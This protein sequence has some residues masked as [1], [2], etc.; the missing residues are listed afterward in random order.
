M[1][2]FLQSFLKILSPNQILS[3]WYA[4]S[5]LIFLA[6]L[7]VLHLG[8]IS[9]LIINLSDLDAVTGEINFIN[10]MANIIN[11][12]LISPSVI[13][14]TSIILFAI[15]NTLISTVIIKHISVFSQNLGI[16]IKAKIIRHYLSLTWEDLGQIP[17]S[18][19]MSRILNDG[20][21]VADSLYFAL[22]LMSKLVLAI[23]ISALLFFYN[24][25]ITLFIVF[26][27]SVSYC[28][29][30]YLFSRSIKKNSK[31]VSLAE[32][33]ILQIL[34]NLFGSL[35]EIIFYN[36]S[37]RVLS[38]FQSIGSNFA[39]AKGSNL[40][41]AQIPR[42]IIDSLLLA[43]IV[44]GILIV[45]LNAINPAAFFTMISVYGIAALKLLPAFQNVF[46]FAQEIN[47]R[48]PN[49]K[50]IAD[51]L[52]TDHRIL[53]L[54]NSDTSQDLKLIKKI[55][56]HDIGYAYPLSS[57]KSLSDLSLNININTDN[58]IAII[59][60]S[61]SGKS[62]FLDILL[63]LISPNSGSVEVNDQQLTHQQINSYRKNFTY[64]PQKIFFIEGTLR[65]N[66][67]FGH[68]E[69]AHEPDLLRVTQEHFLQQLIDSLPHGLETFLSDENQMVSGG[70]K[71]LIGIARALIRGG[72]ILVLDEATSAMDSALEASVYKSIFSS[73]FKI[74]IS[75]THDPK[76][77]KFFDKI[78]ILNQGSIEDFGTYD[79]L[80]SK[81]K[82]AK[83]MF[84]KNLINS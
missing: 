25:P 55:H 51:L 24:P 58:K 18:E 48:A 79:E 64:V 31:I 21:H 62:T 52:S 78:I 20:M 73:S 47:S 12:S 81:N 40:A 80:F 71:Q 7:E 32:D 22:N 16:A 41:L 63:G 3:I 54:Q 60:P 74:V 59:G 72:D 66:L 13:L 38:E 83:D 11:L 69:L 30:F 49:L 61:G 28:T 26:F 77:L 8:L 4:T 5:L 53:T 9:F 29:L 82:F 46:Y 56:F 67:L 35:K 34:K 50:N 65:E 15:V 76:T 37:K 1:L 33:S 14:C 57:S 36:T 68:I 75:V 44:I 19:G 17:T 42:Y 43:I 70:Q 27:L 10:D 6:I 45:N 39:T 84:S 23:M 2:F